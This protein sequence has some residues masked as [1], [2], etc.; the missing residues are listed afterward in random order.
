MTPDPAHIP[1]VT[2]R[3][4][5]RDE[6]AQHLRADQRLPDYGMLLTSR[7][8][9]LQVLV[10]NYGERQP[11]AEDVLLKLSRPVMGQE[12]LDTTNGNASFSTS[13]R[14]LA[15]ALPFEVIVIQC[16]D[17][18]ARRFALPNRTMLMSAKWA[19]EQLLVRYLAYARP[20]SE[21]VTLG[22][23]SWETIVAGWETWPTVRP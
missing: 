14:L 3:H 7:P 11:G 9:D 21:A 10:L 2:Q 22:P 8:A 19:D 23:L 1:S 4:L 16:N 17:M 20:V 6:L 18:A 13:G 5:R 15:L 12:V